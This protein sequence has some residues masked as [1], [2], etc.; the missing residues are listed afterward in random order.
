MRFFRAVLIRFEVGEK[1][2]G[3]QSKSAAKKSIVEKI[4]IV[5]HHRYFIPIITALVDCDDDACVCVLVGPFVQV[6]SESPKKESPSRIKTSDDLIEVE[7]RFT[8]AD[9]DGI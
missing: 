5:R 8:N 6:T 3:S 9:S 2:R 1:P 7:P 4:F